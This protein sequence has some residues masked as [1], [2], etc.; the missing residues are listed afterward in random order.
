MDTQLNSD[1]QASDPVGTRQALVTS[2]LII[3]FALGGALVAVVL[4]G[5]DY[6]T[7]RADI[8]ALIVV[9]MLGLVAMGCIYYLGLTLYTIVL[10]Y[11]DPD[12]QQ[13][14]IAKIRA[15]VKLV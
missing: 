8:W 3:L 13:G 2:A 4:A 12:D 15:K 7:D 9:V 11:T 1:E 10:T 14:R 5:L 6:R